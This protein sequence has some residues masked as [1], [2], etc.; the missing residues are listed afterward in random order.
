M[1]SV[2]GV[3]RILVFR[4]RE[5][6]NHSS[7]T[8]PTST[9][10]SGLEEELTVSVPK[11]GDGWGLKGTWVLCEHQS[12]IALRSHPRL[13]LTCIKYFSQVHFKFIFSFFNG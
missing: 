6:E 2:S 3:A 7:S 4:E 1:E 13:I 12:M 11:K 9:S 5:R 8:L 10:S